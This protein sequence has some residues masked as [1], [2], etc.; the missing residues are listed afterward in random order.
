M[1]DDILILGG[2][3]HLYVRGVAAVDDVLFGELEGRGDRGRAHFAECDKCEPHLGT[4]LQ[5]QHDAVALADSKIGE[6]ISY[7][8]G[9]F[10]DVSECEFRLVAV[11]VE[12]EQRRLR[13]LKPSVFVDDIVTEVEIFGDYNAVIVLEILIAVKIDSRKVS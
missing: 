5:Y 4:L 9:V 8:I 2:D 12:P 7:A 11:V 1:T 3:Y 6:Q 10:L 13:R